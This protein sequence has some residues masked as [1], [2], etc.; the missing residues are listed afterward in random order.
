[1]IA[2]RKRITLWKCIISG[3]LLIT[4]EN[5]QA[6]S[7]EQ[8][9]PEQEDTE[10]VAVVN[11]DKIVA[12]KVKTDN[13]DLVVDTMLL[14]IGL[15]AE[16]EM[17]PADELYDG[18]WDNEYVK[19]YAN[20][21]V[22]DTYSIDVS[23]FVM[24]VEGKV[25]S[26]YGK[27][28]RRFHYGT[29]IKLQT[30]DT[31]RAAF[32]GKV[33]IEKYE[34]RGY[35]YYIVLRHANGLETVYGHLSKFLVEEGENITAGQAIALGGNTGRSTGAHLHFEFR[36]LGRAINPGEIID[37]EQF[38][39]KDEVY[40]YEKGKSELPDASSK[41]IAKGKGKINYYRIK[42]GDTLSSIALRTGIS[43]SKLCKL[44]KIKPSGTLRVG[45]SIRLS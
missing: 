44:N 21:A 8:V 5:I 15:E 22:P 7:P 16:E 14:R 9:Q 37:F 30:G 12:N 11:S 31:V 13:E 39:T 40:V 26:K 23:E 28:R 38:C 36:F 34:R 27:R 33:R 2:K 3:I 18:E 17:F 6:Q 45:R 24:P 20:I 1:M 41:Y 32:S 10:P 43:V 42:K 19:A 29:D 4:A 25:T 35:G